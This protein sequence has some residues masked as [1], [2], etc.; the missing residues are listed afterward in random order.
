MPFPITLNDPLSKF[1]V[2]PLFAAKYLGNGTIQRHS[3][4][5]IPIG[6]Y[7]RLIKGVIS[8]DFE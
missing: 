4:N 8:N 6:I 5:G 3:Y 7:K 1:K 2:T